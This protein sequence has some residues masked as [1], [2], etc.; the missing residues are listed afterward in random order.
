MLQVLR[1]RCMVTQLCGSTVSGFANSCKK[2]GLK[3]LGTW[4][5]WTGLG[6]GGGFR[7]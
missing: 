1:Q 3:R 5:W 7:E 2:L 6:M 4:L